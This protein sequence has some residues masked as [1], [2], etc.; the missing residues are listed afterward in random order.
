MTNIIITGHDHHDTTD[1]P[2]EIP[3]ITARGLNN[4]AAQAYQQGN[5]QLALEY[6]EHAAAY[7][8][9]PYDT[10]APRLSAGRPRHAPDQTPP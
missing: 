9:R 1:P 4:L 7:D 6:L 2:A 8:E 3:D 10:P 5:I